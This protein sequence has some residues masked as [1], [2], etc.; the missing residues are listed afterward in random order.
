[1]SLPYA[2]R[3]LCLCLEMLFLVNLA[4]CGVVLLLSRAAARAAEGLRPQQAARLFLGLRLL[5]FASSLGVVGSL[6]IPSYLRYE[7]NAG[8]EAMG[9][10]CLAAAALGLALCVS[11]LWRGLRALGQLYLLDRRLGLEQLPPAQFAEAEMCVAG[12]E[13]A[14]LPLLALVGIVRPRLIVSRRLLQAL[15]AEQ[16][17]AALSHERA[18]LLGRD[19]LKRLLVAVTPG[20]LPF[21]GGLGALERQWERYAELAADDFAARSQSGRS[22]A[23]AEALVRVA[24]LGE[25]ARRMPLASSLSDSNLELARRVNR[26][27][28]TDASAAEQRRPSGPAWVHLLFPT[29]VCAGLLALLPSLIGPVYPLLE[30]LLH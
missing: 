15:S 1:M 25:D 18:H 21:A 22:V 5:P 24:R 10:L 17:E 27:L 20:L 2:M 19:N 6:C 29:V 28:Q 12:P 11:A 4:A 7:Q 8:S 26:L 16:F 3:L 23:L 13:A 30:S 9:G 14:G